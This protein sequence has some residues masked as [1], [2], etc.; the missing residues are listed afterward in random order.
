MKNI[1]KKYRILKSE[2]LENCGEGGDIT[3]YL[4][5]LNCYLMIIWVSLRQ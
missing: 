3:G 4:N 1:N 2:F 5:N